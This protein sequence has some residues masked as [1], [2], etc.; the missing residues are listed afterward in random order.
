MERLKKT[1][2]SLLFLA[3][4]ICSCET[5]AI[6]NSKE[7]SV[8]HIEAVFYTGELLPVII[9]GQ[10]VNLPGKELIVFD[11]SDFMLD[12]ADVELIWNDTPTPT[13]QIG[14]GL[15]Q[16]ISEVMISQ[17]DVF[18]IVVTHN[19][20]TAKATAVVPTI[21]QENIELSIT[22][23]VTLNESRL[24][25]TIASDTAID[26]Y[27]RVDSTAWIGQ[28]EVQ[29]VLP[30][31]PDFTY[32]SSFSTQELTLYNSE[33]EV[34]SSYWYR[35]D[36]FLY[37]SYDNHYLGENYYGF[38]HLTINRTNFTIAQSEEDFEKGYM[39]LEINYEVVIPEPIYADYHQLYSTEILPITVTNIENG[40]GLFIGAVKINQ[41]ETKE[42]NILRGKEY[43]P[44]D[45]H[46]H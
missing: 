15:Y 24:T 12:D 45:D 14:N 25:K 23:T 5:E 38:D 16:G 3:W 11:S 29:W 6:V 9:V 40:V 42:I 37:N 46:F 13:R 27:I 33:W 43:D 26:G 17:G 34:Y 1:I 41:S 44:A 8:L 30:I 19:G 39:S 36:L 32:I 2:G 35:S 4:T 7:P 20:R 31:L 10:S 21:N 22:D 28:A 18:K